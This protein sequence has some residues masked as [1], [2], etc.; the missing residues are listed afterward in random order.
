MSSLS[1]AH[2]GLKFSCSLCSS[3]FSVSMSPFLILSR[4]LL[5]STLHSSISSTY[6]LSVSVSPSLIAATMG[7]S[8]IERHITLERAMYGSDQA[9]S[10][11]GPGLRQ[12]VAQ[13]RKIPVTLGVKEKQITDGEKVAAEKLRYWE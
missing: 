7:A 6:S 5:N 9:A 8:A 11:E 12:L 3:S 1:S 10:L 4:N 13:V 2:S